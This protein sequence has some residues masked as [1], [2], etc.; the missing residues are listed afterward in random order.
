MSMDNSSH[1]FLA[2]HRE[3]LREYAPLR[4]LSTL[5]RFKAT[6]DL[7]AANCQPGATVLDLGAWPGILAGCFARLGF[8]VIAVD[9]DPTRSLGWKQ[10]MLLDQHGLPRR[11]GVGSLA[12]LCRSEKVT[13]IAAD[14]ERDSLPLESDSVDAVLLT[15]V[16]EHLWYDPVWALSEA[17]RVL[18]PNTGI[19]LLST[20]NFLSLRNRLQFLFGNIDVVI[21][22]PFVSFLKAKRIGH[23]GHCRLYAPSELTAML[24]L[25]GFEPNLFFSRYGLDLNGHFMTDSPASNGDPLNVGNGAASNGRRSRPALRLG[26]LFRSPRGYWSAA[27]ATALA[28]AEQWIPRFRPQMFIVGRKVSD[29]DFARN[30]PHETEK[31]VMTNRL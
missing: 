24:C 12:E 27:S 2:V 15:E 14:I 22:N 21:E 6:F 4:P 5:S 17:N 29:A 16:I 19:L 25:L 8:T 28:C 7:L 13:C 10:D 30:R 26:R 3:F 18:K 1:Q 11:D 23:L 9:K 31:L 20:P